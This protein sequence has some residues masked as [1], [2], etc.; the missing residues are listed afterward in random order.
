VVDPAARRFSG[1]TG[2]ADAADSA[3]GAVIDGGSLAVSIVREVHQPIEHLE[4]LE[5]DLRGTTAG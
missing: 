1:R 5:A 2:V 3:A 4:R